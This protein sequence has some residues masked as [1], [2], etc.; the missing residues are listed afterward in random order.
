MKTTHT[1]YLS[2]PPLR[3]RRSLNRPPN[4]VPISS[5]QFCGQRA[6]GYLCLPFTAAGLALR[7]FRLEYQYLHDSSMVLQSGAPRK[8]YET[9]L[10]Q[11]TW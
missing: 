9:M 5:R 7:T 11:L 6:V 4:R 10:H 1:R 8:M 2:R 3:R